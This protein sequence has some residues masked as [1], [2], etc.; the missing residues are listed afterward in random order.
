[1]LFKSIKYIPALAALII[2]LVVAFTYLL[3][4]Q[5][6]YV[7]KKESIGKCGVVDI[8]PAIIEGKAIFDA[9]CSM[10]H[11]KGKL[12]DYLAGKVQ[13]YGEEFIRDY[14]TKEDS[15]L[16]AND[17]LAI[18]I[19]KNWNTEGDSYRHRYKFSKDELDCLIEYLK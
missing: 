1:M 2:T 12:H 7:E 8:P 19:N 5:P 17:K 15:L 9:E 3:Y 16:N 14:I 13:E 10:C 18:T 4:K 6:Q 11:K